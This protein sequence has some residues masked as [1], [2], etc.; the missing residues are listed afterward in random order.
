[1]V[2]ADPELPWATVCPSLPPAV[3]VPPL[4]PGWLLAGGDGG[5]RFRGVSAPPAERP[6]VTVSFEGGLVRVGSADPVP[7]GDAA[8]VVR[9]AAVD[10]RGPV[11]LELAPD[12][13]W[14]DV[15]ALVEL[16]ATHHEPA[17]PPC[18][19]WP[20]SAEPPPPAAPPALPPGAV[21][22][23]GHHPR[24][25][26][27][28]DLPDGFLAAPQ[29]CLFTVDVGVD[30]VPAGAW[31]VVCPEPLVPAAT[32]AVMAARWAPWTDGSPS[33]VRTQVGDPRRRALNEVAGWFERPRGYGRFPFGARPAG[34]RRS[35]SARWSQPA[36]S[37]SSQARR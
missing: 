24:D 1:V 35:K 34:F 14:A 20:P 18:A 23:P 12:T 37:D 36:V 9:F 17:L 29:R 15:V 4:G 19:G 28:A 21:E 11:G 33:R 31:V 13:P 2:Q 3:G 22:A 7:R 25:P 6:S 26:V 5:L 16:V 10:L 30:G 32:A 8:R 27:T